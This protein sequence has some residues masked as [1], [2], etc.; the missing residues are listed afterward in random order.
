MDGVSFDLYPGEVLGLVG[1]SGSGKS[2]TLRSLVRL[3]RPPGVV[4]GAF[5]G[6]T[7]SLMTL[8]DE[9]LRQV[10]GGEISMIFQEPISALNPVLSVGEQIRETLTRAHQPGPAA[11]GQSRPSNC[12]AWSASRRPPAPAAA[13]LTS[14]RAACASV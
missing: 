14:F 3:I 9:E 1:E 10:R 8:S 11:T 6:R 4:D 7:V 13:I 12:C 2:V 5:T